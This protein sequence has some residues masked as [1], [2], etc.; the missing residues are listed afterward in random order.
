MSPNSQLN[1]ISSTEA[2]IAQMIATKMNLLDW[3]DAMLKNLKSIRNCL[4]RKPYLM[5]NYDDFTTQIN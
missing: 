5:I 4:M 3:K 2:M 1:S